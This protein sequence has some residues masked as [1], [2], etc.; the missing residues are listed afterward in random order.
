M[1]VFGLDIGST[2]IK[3]ASVQKEGKKYRLVSAGVAQTPPPGLDSEAEKDLVSLASAIKKLHQDARINNKNAVVSLPESKIFSRVITVPSMKEDELSQALQWEAEQFIPLPIGDV[4]LDSIVISRGEAG[5][6]EQMMEVLVVAAPKNLIKKYQHLVELA[7]FGLVAIETELIAVARA[8]L[9]PQ[10]PAV[11][12]VD[13]GAETTDIAIAKKG[14]LAFTR[15]IPAGGQAF[16]RAVSTSLSIDPAQAEKYKTAYGL[17]EKKLEG[18]VK[19]AITPVINQ[20]VGEIKKAAQF[21]QEKEKEAIKTMILTGGS[22]NLPEMTSFLTKA[23]T[24]EVQVADPFA[25]LIKNEKQ[26]ANLRQN[27]PLFAVVIGLAMK[28]I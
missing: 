13:F 5:K 7:G 20:V 26:V 22:T 21:W 18:K 23:L 25:N 16:T 27:S 9:S 10:S 17:T 3:I 4:S 1:N 28:E 2:S 11:V 6:V 14:L 8:L 15:S 24:L 12:I 19:A